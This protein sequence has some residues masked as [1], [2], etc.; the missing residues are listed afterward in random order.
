[1]F[2]FKVQYPIRKTVQKMLFVSIPVTFICLCVAFAF[3]LASFE[4]D[5]LLLEYFR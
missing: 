4:A 3:M 2:I 1:M 5:R